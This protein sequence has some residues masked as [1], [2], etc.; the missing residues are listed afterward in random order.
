VRG[1]LVFTGNEEDPATVETIRALGFKQPSTVIET[2]KRWHYGRYRAMRSA[3]SRE[4]LT[5][6]TPVLLEAFAAT[7][8]ADLALATFDGFL[9]DLPA[10]LQLFSALRANPELLRLIA[11][12]MG[13]APRLARLLSK[14][15]RLLD[16]ILD[17][18]VESLA[19]TRG[20]MEE[21]FARAI[22]EART[23]EDKLNRARIV[24]QEKAFTIGTALL[25][26]QL[27][28]EQAGFAYSD[29][30]EAAV[31]AVLDIVQGQFGTA[32][33]PP[34]AIIAMGKC[35]GR[36]MTANSDLDLIF[37]YDRAAA[38]QH[39]ARFTQRFIGAISA[40]TSEGVLYTVDT[41]LRPSGKAG[42][43]AV[44]SEGFAAY[45][46]DQAWTWEHLALTRARVIAGPADLCQSLRQ[47]IKDVLR[48]R[49]DPQ[50]IAAD[51]QDM[52]ALVLKEKPATDLWDT[53][54]ARGGLI[55]VEFIAQYLQLVHAQNHPAIL[56]TNTL[57]ALQNAAE[58][59]VLDRADAS[60]LAEA[61]G[62][63]QTV[64]H[65]LRLCVEGRFDPSRASADL[66]RLLSTL[67]GEPDLARIE[68]RLTELY[69]QVTAA[70]ERIIAPVAEPRG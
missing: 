5:E 58:A 53:K 22:G 36:E 32:D 51:V 4:I 66:A 63:Y 52:R 15:H 16:A 42:P 35:G 45:Q 1:N 19:G 54:L 33:L 65:V 31:R 24:G 23:Y 30:A 6:F 2:L 28:P 67:C 14:R 50:K 8:D 37:V 68:A 56:S 64:S 59:G 7:S 60:L 26:R 41:R 57:K 18:G 62:L 40:P 48:M 49:R 25:S 17:P 27:S 9:S 44:Q 3:R 47:D 10:A 39:Y 38:S 34:P 12:I 29:L 55:D 13:S 21:A 46:R 61:T 70:F 11:Q 69:A 43:V 20:E